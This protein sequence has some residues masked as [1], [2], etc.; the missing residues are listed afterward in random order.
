MS[1]ETNLGLELSSWLL[2]R[3]LCPS[4]PNAKVLLE[5]LRSGKLSL[6][7]FFL[8]TSGDLHP[9]LCVPSGAGPC[10]YMSSIFRFQTL[11]QTRLS[12]SCF[13]WGASKYHHL[14][15]SPSAYPVLGTQLPEPN[16]CLPILPSFPP[17]FLQNGI[18]YVGGGLNAGC[19]P[20]QI[21]IPITGKESDM[22]MNTGQEDGFLQWRQQSE[23]G[24][25]RPPSTG[26]EP[27]PFTKE[28]AGMCNEVWSVS[29]AGI[30]SLIGGETISHLHP[31][32]RSPT[33]PRPPWAVCSFFGPLWTVCSCY[34]SAVGD[35]QATSCSIWKVCPLYSPRLVPSFLFKRETE[36]SFLHVLSK[37]LSS[38]CDSPQGLGKQG[39]SFHLG[40]KLSVIHHQ[41]FSYGKNS[42]LLKDFLVW[43][44]FPSK[45]TFWVP[46]LAS[47]CH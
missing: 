14:L 15:E 35:V 38:R 22:K 12:W 5:A 10:H 44:A 1:F 20:P 27:F 13:V 7:L 41:I 8:T 3:I 25:E 26:M 33:K 19:F 18:L 28:K 6:F 9:A 31:S 30:Q 23:P 47:S 37:F 29:T 34:I 2:M 36:V 43:R 21:L 17:G 11:Q 16:S 39:A 24:G 32:F 45:V 46:T 40:M 4:P 42:S